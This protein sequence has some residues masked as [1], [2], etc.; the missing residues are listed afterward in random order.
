ML[1]KDLEQCFSSNRP[2]SPAKTPSRYMRAI[3]EYFS[4]GESSAGGM[5]E[6]LT[7]FGSIPEGLKQYRM[8]NSGWTMNV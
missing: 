6:I 3:E 7:A 5:G 2:N 1:E 4:A 8:K